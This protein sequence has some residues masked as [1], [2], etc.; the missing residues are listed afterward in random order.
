M[1]AMRVRADT[2]R[3]RDPGEGRDP[4]RTARSVDHAPATG[5]SPAASGHAGSPPVSHSFGQVRVQ[6]KLVAG[7][8]GDPFEQE[9]EAEADRVAAAALATGPGRRRHPAPLRALTPRAPAPLPSPRDLPRPARRAWGPAGDALEAGPRRLMEGRLGH[10][11]RHVRVHTDAAA[12]EATRELGALA[13]TVGDHVFFGRGRYQ[14]GSPAGRSLLAHELTHVVQQRTTTATPTLQARS[15]FESIGIFLGLTEGTFSD[16]ELTAYLDKVTAAKKIEDSYD[17]D[18]KARAVVRRWE[19]G[20]TAFNLTSTQKALLVLEMDSG[21]VG[22]EDQQG[23]LTLLTK[24]DSADLR[25]IFTSGGVKAKTLDDDFGGKRRHQLRAFFDTRFAGGRAA[26]FA[27]TVEPNVGAP[28]GAPPF[29]YDA[30]VLA[31]KAEGGATSAD[32]LA[33]LN[34]FPAA[35]VDRA[36]AD[37]TAL[38]VATFRQ[39]TKAIEDHDAAKDPKAK[40]ALEAEVKR[41]AAVLVAIEE[42]I[43]SLSR[44]VAV[45]ETPASLQAKTT[46][47]AGAQKTAATEALAPDV[48]VDPT[49]GKS[50]PFVEHFP[51]EKDGYEKK[52]R[53]FMPTM[54]K[55]YVDA[56]VVDKGPA[57]HADPTKVHALKELEDI[58]NVSK[59]ETDKVFGAYKQGAPLKADTKSKRGNIHDLWADTDKELKSLS[60]GQRRE[61]ARQLLFYFFQ[62]DDGIL[63]F[64]AHHN[65]QPAFA[66]DGTPTNDEAKILKRIADDFT[67]TDAEVTQL[68]EIDRGWDA[69]AQAGQINIQIFKRPDNDADRDFLWDM[70]QTLIHEYL[71][72]LA[73]KAYNDFAHSFGDQSN[74]NN[75]LVEGVDSFLD[76][77]VWRNVEPR[78]NDPD[79]RK[80]IE[81]P[82][83]AA[84]PPLTVA[85]ARRRRYPSYTQALKLVD[86]VGVRNLYAA[87]FLGDVEK[88]GG[89]KKV[90]P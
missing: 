70:F 18:N 51:S 74:E 4:A 71:H 66:P 75:T 73:A 79:L 55:S 59:A 63:A 11:F 25:V 12:A 32:L 69:S 42:A 24:S 3:S 88:I 48:H 19:A 85:P 76:E 46:A 45:S 84:L 36:R 30:K 43:E 78:V 72:T 61:K 7:A 87:Y 65:A 20:A 37:L 56:M 21:W 67:A 52:I 50:K 10:D 89:P 26:L 57:E 81:G 2:P 62:S 39:R 90:A 64:N 82:A 38:R 34:A 1:S 83:N 23:M 86:V 5:A 15:I 49:T 17:S 77:V 47:P 29:P 80:K 14:P 13:Y 53:D 9:A 8:P 16:A 44:D 54:V 6:A 58:G 41:Q 22:S 35:D 33:Y 60:K 27:G 31:A 28:A 68:N 40:E